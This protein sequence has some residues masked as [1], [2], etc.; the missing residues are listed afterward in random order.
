MYTTLER[1]SENLAELIESLLEQAVAASGATRL[2]V[3]TIDWRQAIVH[4][5]DAARAQTGRGADITL[6]LPEPDGPIV[7]SG[8]AGK[9]ERVVTNLLSNAA[10]FST[11]GTP[12]TVTLS[13][14]GDWIEIEVDDRGEGI[15]EDELA[16]VFERFHQ[17]DS[18]P[19]RAAGGVGIGLS[20][21]Q[22]FVE[23]HG[24]TITVASRVG[25][26]STFTVRIPKLPVTIELPQ[27]RRPETVA[28]SDA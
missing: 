3:G 2:A 11:P 21:V 8:D 9:L 6:H 23:A 25:D 16:R 17:V 18:G 24:G 13:D 22:H 28:A 26:C 19:T 12:I 14:D 5:T 27:P 15:P 1:R 7:G 4:W 20:L 10:K